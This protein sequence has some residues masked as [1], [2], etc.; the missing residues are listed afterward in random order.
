MRFHQFALHMPTMGK[1]SLWPTL[2]SNT[3][4]DCCEAE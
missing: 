2:S 4:L 3:S 1:Q